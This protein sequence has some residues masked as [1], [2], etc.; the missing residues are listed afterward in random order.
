MGTVNEEVK[1]DILEKKA[2]GNFKHK[3]PSTSA[4]QVKL[5]DTS[6][7][8]TS[9]N[10]ED[11]MT[12][13]FTNVSNG[14]DLVSGAITDVDD[15]IAIPTKPSFND[16]A[17]AIEGI[18]LIPK[19]ANSVTKNIGSFGRFTG[20][21]SVDWKTGDYYMQGSS[22]SY[23]VEKYDALG[24][25]IDSI[26][27]ITFAESPL[28]AGQNIVVTRVSSGYKFYDFNGNLLFMINSDGM[29]LYRTS[30]SKILYKSTD[31]IYIAGRS[32]DSGYMY[33]IVC[34]SL[35][36]ITTRHEKRISWST[37]NLLVDV[38]NDNVLFI[39]GNAFVLMDVN[40]DFSTYDAA[41][42]MVSLI[43]GGEYN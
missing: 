42:L 13:L 14:K 5:S 16:L 33:F 41:Y 27:M 35:G 7:L 22:S 8:F 26:N 34:D 2:D 6:N 31:A 10:V 1:I 37:R 25:L 18:S 17:N 9:T 29:G 3:L 11:G 39:D 23:V 12:E 38:L 40:Y 4:D 30:D 21:F 15:S 36:N 43:L 28:Y 20:G 24:N 32:T 19:G